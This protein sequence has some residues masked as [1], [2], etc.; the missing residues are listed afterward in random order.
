M[1][2]VSYQ[3]I[4]M[5]ENFQVYFNAILRSK[6]ELRTGVQFSPYQQS[7]EVNIGTQ[8]INVN[9]QGTNKQFAW[10]EISLIY[11]KSHQHQTIYY[12]CGA[13]LGATQIQSLTL[14]NTSSA[15]SLTGVFV[16]DIDN[17]DGRHWLSPMFVAFSCDGC[18]T[19]PL[20]EYTN[21]EIYQELPKEQNYF[22]NTD[23]KRT[24]T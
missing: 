20:T 15:Y 7:F 18:S 12:S 24:L 23:E 9:F 14:E 11:D 19:T 16:Y 1:P 17:E 5:D 6:K 4:T 10:L 3:Q 22:T 13:E 2:Y 21:N 8:T